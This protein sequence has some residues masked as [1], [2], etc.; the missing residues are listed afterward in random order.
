LAFVLD[1]CRAK[2]S[3]PKARAAA[4]SNHDNGHYDM[5][6][7][8]D[9]LPLSTTAG[10][11]EEQIT[12]GKRDRALRECSGE[13][14]DAV[15][16]LRKTRDPLDRRKPTPVIAKFPM[17]TQI[18]GSSVSGSELALCR[19]P[20]HRHAYFIPLVL[21]S[22]FGCTAPATA[23]A[24]H[25]PPFAAKPCSEELPPPPPATPCS[26]LVSR[27]AELREVDWGWGDYATE[28][29]PDASYEVEEAPPE[30]IGASS[31]VQVFGTSRELV[32]CGGDELIEQLGWPRLSAGTS[33]ARVRYEP[34]VYVVYSG[35][36]KERGRVT[37]EGGRLAVELAGGA[38]FV[39]SGDLQLQAAEP[40]LVHAAAAAVPG[41]CNVYVVA[42]A[43]AD[44]AE[45]CLSVPRGAP[46]EVLY[47]SFRSSCR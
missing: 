42:A 31:L 8:L 29:C 13:A 14:T 38:A 20:G 22:T 3:E 30:R 47:A 25:S 21:A 27:M 41:F 2:I 46:N 5:I 28:R 35:C 17:K 24:G 7:K 44:E 15:S 4:A 19:S 6:A 43:T 18:P 32:F 12:I 1:S 45:V 33:R 10:I 36:T 23:S 16:N 26:S 40:G 11:L 9:A 34:G 39:T 37:L